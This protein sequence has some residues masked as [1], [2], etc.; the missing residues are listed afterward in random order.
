[1]LHED[2]ER[3]RDHKAVTSQPKSLMLKNNE[4]E[5]DDKRI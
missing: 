3:E 1:M 2:G 4:R 5:T